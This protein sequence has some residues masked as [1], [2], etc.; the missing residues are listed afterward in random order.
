M[1]SIQNQLFFI[2]LLFFALG[3]IHISLSLLGIACFVLPFIQY[4]KYKD[5]V[6]CKYYC[7]RAGYFNRLIASLS[8]GLKAP[9]VLFSKKVKKGVVVYFAINLLFVTMSTV[10]VTLGRVAPIEQIRF[11]IVLALP[12]QM[13]QLLD[14]QVAPNVL[15]LSYRIYSMMLTSTIVGS[16]LGVLYHPRTWCG[17]CPINTLTTKSNT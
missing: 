5:K 12:F 13:P 4:I 10:M 2:T 7:P 17:L 15:H 3:F 8:F 11:M 6:W 9:K 14:L 1:K 16:I